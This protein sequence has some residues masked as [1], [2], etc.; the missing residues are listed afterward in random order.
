MLDALYR[1]SHLLITSPNLHEAGPT[2]RLF[3]LYRFPKITEPGCK[4]GQ[5]A[6]PSGPGPA[7]ASSLGRG[8]VPD[9]TELLQV[10]FP[11]LPGGSSS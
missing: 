7:T 5:P 10:S 6:P 11:L 8:A 9:D 2:D 4:L 3:S 1:A